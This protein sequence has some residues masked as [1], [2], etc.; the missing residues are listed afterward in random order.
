M[1]FGYIL[2]FL[3]TI[4]VNAKISHENK[5]KIVKRKNGLKKPN[6]RLYIA[7]EKT[8]D[9]NAKDE[10]KKYVNNDSEQYALYSKE[11]QKVRHSFLKTEKHIDLK[12]HLQSIKLKAEQLKIALDDKKQVCNDLKDKAVDYLLAIIENLHSL[13]PDPNDE[14]VIVCDL[15]CYTFDNKNGKKIFSPTVIANYDDR[16]ECLNFLK[17][18][19]DELYEKSWSEFITD[20]IG[21]KYITIHLRL[22]CTQALKLDNISTEVLEN[23]IVET[24][25]HIFSK[26][27][28]NMYFTKFLWEKTTGKTVF[29]DDACKNQHNTMYVDMCYDKTYDLEAY[30]TMLSYTTDEKYVRIKKINLLLNKQDDTSEWIA[31]YCEYMKACNENFDKFL[32]TL[33]EMHVSDKDISNIYYVNFSGFNGLTINKLGCV[34]YNITKPVTIKMPFKT[35]NTIIELRKYYIEHCNQLWSDA[36]IQSL[37]SDD[38]IIV[39]SNINV[40]KN[41]KDSVFTRSIR[42]YPVTTVLFTVSVVSCLI[43]IFLHE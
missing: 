34:S 20:L 42:I 3:C 15:L 8:A 30:K 32:T 24:K 38:F 27:S 31:A 17:K 7:P 29:L 36:V 6:A 35:K 13:D 23:S 10:N 18:H 25:K 26:E 19:L 1:N 40:W 4:Q 22:S 11:N 5:E 9:D 21:E 43:L 28:K 16:Q 12:I 41:Q 39:M 33:N 37:Y 2:I 14:Y